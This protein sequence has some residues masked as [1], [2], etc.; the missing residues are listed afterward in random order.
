LI[1]SVRNTIVSPVWFLH[2]GLCI[3]VN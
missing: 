3:A 1:E 2:I